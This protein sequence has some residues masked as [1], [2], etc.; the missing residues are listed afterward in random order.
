M[1]TRSSEDLVYGILLARTYEHC[2]RTVITGTP[3]KGRGLGL[4]EYLVDTPPNEVLARSPKRPGYGRKGY[5]MKHRIRART[6]SFGLT[7]KQTATTAKKAFFATAKFTR[8]Y[9]GLRGLLMC[10]LFGVDLRSMYLVDAYST[11]RRRKT[12]ATAIAKMQ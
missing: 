11:G 6:I 1:R 5:I 4:V 10:L 2:S 7:C 8:K 9:F 12:C 3:P